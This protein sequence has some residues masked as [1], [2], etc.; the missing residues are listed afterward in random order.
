MRPTYSPKEAIAIA[1]NHY[2]DLRQRGLTRDEALEQTIRA[3]N[4]KLSAS[5]LDVLVM[6]RDN[7]YEERAGNWHPGDAD[8]QRWLKDS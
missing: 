6:A 4:L 1:L 7:D 5:A 2:D 3:F 8:I